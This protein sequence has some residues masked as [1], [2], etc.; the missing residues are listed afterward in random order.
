MTSVREHPP[1][2]RTRRRALVSQTTLLWVLPVVVLVCLV[3]IEELTDTSGRSASGIRITS[4]F[5]TWMLPVSRGAFDVAVFATI[6]SLLTARWLLPGNGLRSTGLRVLRLAGR[7]SLVL[8]VAALCHAIVT[9]AQLVG[10]GARDVLTSPAL[11]PVLWRVPQLRSLLV[12][13]VVALV[14]HLFCARAGEPRVAGP[15][16][17]AVCLSLVPFLANGHASSAR[18]HFAAS[19]SLVVH[20]LAASL[21]VGGLMVIIVHLRSDRTALRA[22]LPRFSA[23]ALGCYVALGVS[24]VIGALVRLDLSWAALPTTYGALVVAKTAALLVLGLL[25]MAHRSWT[26]PGVAAGRPL[27]FV[28]FAFA[29][30][31][32][33]ATATVLAVLLART[34][35][36]VDGLGRP[37]PLH[38]GSGTI[39]DRGIEPLAPQTVLTAFRPDVL[40]LTVLAG[41]LVAHLVTVAHVLRTGGTWR[42]GRSALFV[43]GVLL[44]GWCLCGGLGV[45]AGVLFSNEVS[46]L[47]VMGLVVPALLISGSPR[48]SGPG[49]TMGPFADPVNGLVLFVGVLGAALMTPLM[50]LSLRSP[51]AHIA[52]PVAVTA[53][54]FVFLT[55]LLDADRRARLQRSAREEALLVTVLGGLLLVY[56]VLLATSGT[57][58]AA[59]WYGG[60]RLSWSDPVTD[61][62]RTAIVVACFGLVLLAAAQLRGRLPDRALSPSR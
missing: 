2:L 37:V 34:P 32:L 53:A 22:A 47:L 45:Y 40:V 42:G 62:Q 11:Y 12:L 5:I 29:E 39:L 57:L 9:T 61:Q 36:P 16:L 58:F 56:A 51:A 24:G 41:L 26:L 33:M 54:G 28:R 43:A 46:R 4:P 21:W 59:E 55:P 52:L 48:R 10:V 23:L 20:V 31:A 1:H 25:G 6:G 49:W 14:V 50:E 13:A 27:A 17:V 3:L 44:A 35:P 15:L 60:L 8:T 19:Q 7:W 30:L 18:N 38:T